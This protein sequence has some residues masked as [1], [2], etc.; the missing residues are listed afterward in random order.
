MLKWV[1]NIV[2]VCMAI[3]AGE[4]VLLVTDEPM[5][6]MRMELVEQI[7][8]VGP[9]EL[10]SYVLPDATR[11]LPHYP[12]MLYDLAQQVDV[13]LIFEHRRN[14]EIETPRALEMIQ[15]LEKGHARYAS[16]PM[17]NESIL[18]HE[19]SADYK[20]IAA[21]TNRL[22][23]K[24]KG[25]SKVHVTTPLGTDL[26]LDITGRDIKRDTGLFHK[27]HEHGN[28]PAGE[29]YVAPIEDQT[30]GVFIVDKS[31]PGILIEEPIYLTVEHGRVV[32]IQGGREAQ[33]LLDM[34]EDGERK[35]NGEGCRV[36]CELG[37]GTNPNARLQG[38]VLT[39]EKVM[40]TVHIAI[41][42]N[43][44]AA[45][46]GQNHAPIHLDGVIGQP[47]LTVD[48]QTLIRDGEYLV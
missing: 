11:P 26:Y 43:A 9:S 27:P 2:D 35:P 23:D 32:D 5:A 14:P 33:R 21:L 15:A 7:A 17:I 46:G 30:E 16:G 40:G 18:E 1:E 36:V 22:G 12:A 47:T 42:H 29:C 31:Y 10:W 41:G 45:Y 48:G 19:L 37:I 8:S 44:L 20:K 38:N 13:A 34:I 3:Q 24:L 39:D 4:K 6:I 25:R 28:L